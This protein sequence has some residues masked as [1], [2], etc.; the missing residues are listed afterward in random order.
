MP[1]QRPAERIRNFSEVPLGYTPEVAQAE[2]RRCLQCK[3][4]TCIEGCPVRIDIPGFIRAIEEGD[5][6]RSATILKQTNSLPAVC[7]RV[8]PQEVECEV[9]CV[10]AKKG[11]PICIGRL[12]R[13]AADWER[14]HGGGETPKIMPATGQKVAVVGSGPAGLTCAAELAKWGH[15]VTVFEAL[16][17]AGGVLVYG[18]PEFR[19]P[20]DILAVEVDNLRDLG[21]TIRCNYIVGQLATI[22]ELMQERGFSAVFIGSGAGLPKFLGI[23]GENLMGVYSANEFLTRCNLMRS[24]AFPEYDTPVAV[25]QSVAVVGGGNVAMDSARAA[26]RLGAENVLILYRRSREEMPARIEEIHHAEEEGIRLELLA[27]PVALIGDREG[28]LK[29]VRC[30]R[31]ELGEP[32]A[33]GRR[34]PV[35]IPGSEFEILLD[36]LIVAVGAGAHPL[37]ARTTPGLQVNEQGYIMI[38]EESAMSSK[39]GV[40]AGGDIVTGAATVIE[41]MGA[42]KRAAR[43]IQRYLRLEVPE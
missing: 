26:K 22:D 31:N 13:F 2:A 8:C 25:G 23:Q 41:A 38:G 15:E 32:D 29:A 14:V 34:R 42:G 27:N 10:L 39:P 1:E 30:I 11:Q 16:H 40:F 4:P 36:N 5:F 19:L 6:A 7:G 43:G 9:A 12:E 24:Y 21:V 17:E 33:S 3:Q 37:I 28:W 20:K 35:P 18:I